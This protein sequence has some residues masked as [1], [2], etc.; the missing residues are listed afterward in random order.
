MTPEFYTDLFLKTRIGLVYYAEKMIGDFYASDV[1]ADTFE[2]IWKQ[3]IPEK[4]TGSEKQYLYLSVNSKCMNILTE[5]GRMRKPRRCAKEAKLQYQKCSTMRPDVIQMLSMVDKSEEYADSLAIKSD[6]I[7]LLHSK[8]ETLTDTQKGIFTHAFIEERGIREIG[9]I[10]G[11][12]WQYVGKQK[13]VIVQKLS[14]LG[15]ELS[16]NVRWI[17]EGNG[18]R[19]KLAKR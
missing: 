7:N 13:T 16:N 17:R 2:M 14:S 6:L 10:L 5:K 3:G 8:Y 4:Y 9:K 12:H 11:L 1:V 19:P 18:C 15:I